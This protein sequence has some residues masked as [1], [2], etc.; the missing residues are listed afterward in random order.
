[1]GKHWWAWNVVKEVQ[2]KKKSNQKSFHLKWPSLNRVFCISGCLLIHYFNQLCKTVCQATSGSQRSEAEIEHDVLPPVP[3][4]L[5]HSDDRNH[6]SLGTKLLHG[7]GGTRKDR[8]K[9]SSSEKAASSACD[10]CCEAKI[11]FYWDRK[12][13]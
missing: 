12:C 2:Q 9:R 6:S 7:E 5:L 1:M 8:G 11:K 10:W 3:S 13:R 4:L